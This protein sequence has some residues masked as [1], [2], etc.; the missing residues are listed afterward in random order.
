[1]GKGKVILCMALRDGLVDGDRYIHEGETFEAEKCPSWA[2]IVKSPALKGSGGNEG[3][4]DT[5]EN[6]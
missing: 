3:V 2:V 4:G 5:G 6:A 1:M